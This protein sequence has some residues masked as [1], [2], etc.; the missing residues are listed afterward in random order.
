[1]NASRQNIIVILFK[2][3]IFIL[4]FNSFNCQNID[5]NQAE[6]DYYHDNYDYQTTVVNQVLEFENFP[7]CC[8]FDQVIHHI[9]FLKSILN[10]ESKLLF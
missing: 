10:P 7:K 4:I 5:D 1:M 9:I 3:L 8:P 2:L 6:N